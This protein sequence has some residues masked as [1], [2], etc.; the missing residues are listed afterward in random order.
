MMP[1]LNCAEARPGG[2]GTWK[3]RSQG[4]FVPAVALERRRTCRAGRGASSPVDGGGGGDDDD[5]NDDIADAC[6]CGAAATAAPPV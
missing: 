3:G 2:Y 4:S 1:T 6:R 5:N